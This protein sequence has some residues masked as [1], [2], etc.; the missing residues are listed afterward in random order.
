MDARPSRPADGADKTPTRDIVVVVDLAN[1]M[2][3]RPDGW[4]R[5]RKAAATRLLTALGQV[6][7]VETAGPDG[8]GL[9]I[10]RI[11]AVLE[12]ASRGAVAPGAVRVTNTS[13]SVTSEIGEANGPTGSP[14]IEVVEA[15]HDGDAAIVAVTER[16]FNAH[17]LSPVISPG[18]L[19]VTADR[20]LRRRL[21]HDTVIVGPDWAN[22]LIDR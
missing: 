8:S 2:G 13:V 9:R 18:V 15:E 10:A 20:G 7:G 3:S 5:D 12:G 11:V 22:R 16:L 17:R 6:V 21:P 4:W 1:V 14:A 19:V